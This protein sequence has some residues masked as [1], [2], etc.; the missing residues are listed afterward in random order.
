MRRRNIGIC[1]EVDVEEGSLRSLEHDSL[2]SLGGV[3]GED[4]NVVNVGEKALAVL[5]VLSR[6]SVEVESLAAVNVGDYLVL[7]LAC[8]LYLLRE[9]LGVNEVVYADSAALVLI[10]ICRTYAALCSADI[11][12]AAESLGETVKLDMPRHNDVSAG[13]NFK[14]GSG[15]ASCFKAVELADEVLG[16]E[17]YAGA[18]KAESVLVE[19]TRGNEVELVYLSVIN[20]GMTRVVT[21][22]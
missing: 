15:Y 12:A 2:A 17:N 10:H 14:V 9:H 19:N 20:Y 1:A 16:V 22:L 13:V 4:G 7:E 6:N 3:E 8:G 11:L 18:D 5:C 21:A